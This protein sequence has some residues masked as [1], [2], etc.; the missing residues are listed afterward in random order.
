MSE[1]NSESMPAEGIPLVQHRARILRFVRLALAIGLVA[2]VI[3]LLW[4][5]ETRQQFV[6]SL[7]SLSITAMTGVL[8]LFILMRIAQAFSFK[9]ALELSNRII[10]FDASLALVGIKGLF[11]LGFV[12]LGLAAQTAHGKIA[13]HVPV[14]IMIHANLTQ[15]FLL[16]VALGLGLI[17][18]IILLPHASDIP[19]SMTFLLIGAG[20]A[21]MGLAGTV[22][23]I[24]PSCSVW[25]NRIP[26]VQHLRLGMERPHGEPLR[27]LLLIACFQATTV[28]TR[29]TRVLVIAWSISPDADFQTLAMSVLIADTVGVVPVTPGGIGLR[30]LLIGMLGAAAD[31]YEVFLAAAVIDRMAAIVLNLVHGALATWQSGS[32]SRTN[33]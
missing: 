5:Q 29:V 24:F 28:V 8:L 19:G 4:Q 32:E 26:G 20:C 17:A 18:G 21:A 30:E 7:T 25:L 9:H 3:A 2:I 10:A 16:V 12:G 11:N 23:C 1:Q 33:Q 31:Q 14:R 27:S 13:H 15:L 6:T 22:A